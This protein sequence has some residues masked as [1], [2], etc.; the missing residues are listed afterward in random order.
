M[1]RRATERTQ[2]LRVRF[3]RGPEAGAIGHLEMARVW[4]R[5]LEEAGIA[6]SY[7]EGQRQQ[8]RITIAAGLP[9]GVTSEGELFDVVLAERISPDDLAA[10]VR[11]HLPPGLDP[12]E[13]RE[14]G[15][16]LPSLPTAVRWAEYEV[17]VPTSQHVQPAVDA[18]LARETFPWEDTRGE[19]IRRYDLRPLVQEVTVERC[20]NGTRLRMRLRC[21]ATG[22]GRADQ[23]V[24]AL[25]LPEPTR[26]H[27]LRL[28][29]AESS[30][31]RDAWRRRGRFL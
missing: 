18:L 30:P 26:V 14:V 22:V 5:A 10:R 31:A 16:G 8:P 19:K 23:V 3:A 25:G 7:S 21:D 15:L 28:I 9:V 4:V 20:G 2:R 6:V 12:L 24:R 11:P 17:D 1:S 27:R 13:V 29:L